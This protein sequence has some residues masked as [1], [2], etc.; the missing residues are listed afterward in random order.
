MSDDYRIGDKVWTRV[1]SPVK[2]TT[3][4][5]TL[6]HKGQF[7]TASSNGS[8]GV[9]C[10]NTTNATN[11]YVETLTEN[12]Q[13]LSKGGRVKGFRRSFWLNKQEPFHFIEEYSLD[14]LDIWSTREYKKK[15]LV[16]VESLG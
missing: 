12:V 4:Y 13:I 7:Y 3:Y 16:E 10:I 5:I 6:Y 14:S 8:I 2:L 15:N 1:S 11:P 9:V